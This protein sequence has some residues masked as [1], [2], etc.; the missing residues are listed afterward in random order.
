MVF[1]PSILDLT[2]N[3]V[4][5]PPNL[6]GQSDDSETN[7]VQKSFVTRM[8]HAVA[9][10]SGDV[11]DDPPPVWLTVENIL[12]TCLLVNQSGFVNKKLLLGVLQGLGP[13]DASMVFVGQQN[14][15]VFIRKPMWAP[16]ISFFIYLCMHPKMELLIDFAFLFQGWARCSRVWGIRDVTSSRS[17]PGG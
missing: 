1:E 16:A 12:K 7:D 2:F 3:H 10:I 4:A 13:G 5:F 8:L 17:N 14:A 9:E 15:C 6:P 11:D